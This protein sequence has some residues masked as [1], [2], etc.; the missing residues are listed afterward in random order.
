MIYRVHGWILSAILVRD[1]F[2]IL[3]W[4]RCPPYKRGWSLWSI[5]ENKTQVLAAKLKHWM[6]EL[7]CWAIICSEFDTGL[8]NR[9]FWLKSNGWT[10]RQENVQPTHTHTHA[11]HTWAS[12]FFGKFENNTSV[13]SSIFDKVPWKQHHWQGDFEFWLLFSLME[14]KWILGT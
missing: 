6:D 4:G 11:M 5:V 13:H 7:L 10:T 8:M 3:F 1:T 2:G 9:D 12:H 14:L